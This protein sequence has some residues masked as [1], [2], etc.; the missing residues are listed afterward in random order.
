MCFQSKKK[1]RKR[2]LPR[3][4]FLVHMPAGNVDVWLH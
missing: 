1:Q 3:G 2:K 4:H